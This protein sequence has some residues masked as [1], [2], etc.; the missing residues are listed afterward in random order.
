MQ[1]IRLKTEYLTNPIG[2]DYASPRLFW[3]CIDGSRQTAYELNIKNEDNLIIYE[4]KKVLTN[5]M[6]FDCPIKLEYK[7]RYTWSIRLYDEKDNV[8]KYSSAY[9]ELG[10]KP[11]ERWQ[12]NW[13]TGNYFVNPFKRYKVDYLK[14]E[15][16]S[17]RIKKARLY[18][19]ACGLYYASINNQKVGDGVLTP[20]ISDYRKRVQYQTY[21]VTDLIKEGNNTINVELTD[22]WYRGC[23]GAWGIRNQYGFQTKMLAILELTDI[24]NVVTKI[25]TDDSWSWSNDGEIICAD[26]KDGEIV[27]ARLMPTY[28]KN[29][30]ITNHNVIP[31]CSNNTLISEHECFKPELIITPSGKKVL[32][33]KQNFAG[34]ISFKIKAKQGEK[35]TLLFGELLNNDKEFS[36]DN[37]QL[38]MKNKVTPLQKIEYTCKEGINEYKT[39]FAIFGYQYVLVETNI[40]FNP[41]DFI[42]IALYTDMEE[43]GT[44]ESSNE[45]LNQ[46][47]RNVIWSTKSNS[48]DLPTDCPTRERHGWTGDAQIF[49]NTFLYL[50]D[51]NAFEQKYLNDIYDFQKPNGKLPHIAPIGGSD[52][53]MDGMNGSTGWADAGIIIPYTLYKRYQDERILRKYLKGMEKYIEFMKT[54]C[55]QFY[56]TAKPSHLHGEERRY[57]VNSG[58]SYGEWA[59]PSDVHKMTWVDCAIPHPESSTAYTIYMLDLMSEIEEILGYRDKAKEYKDFSNKCRKSYQALIEKNNEYSLDTNRQANLVRPL[60]LNL[61]NNKQEEFAKQRLIKALDNYDWRIGTGFLSTPLILDVLSKIDKEYA[62]RLLENT[63]CPGWLN[64]AKNSTTIW[65]AWEGKDTSNGGIASLNHYSKGAMCA[66]LFNS[67]CGINVEKD[68]HF[69]IKPLPGGSFTYSKASYMSIYGEVISEWKKTSKGYEYNISIP[70]NTWATIVLPNGKTYNQNLRSKHYES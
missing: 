9:F 68:N 20:G 33:F 30:R 5:K 39:K 27:D 44:F 23:C 57:L 56:I 13:I 51:A 54:R 16:V 48:A 12:A 19:T 28:S 53:Y 2:I 40:D 41:D 6:Y 60:A 21:D 45:L 29:A 32:D 55:G 24:S 70:V 43:V 67:M 36:Q 11:N 22:G 4:S 59:E 46:F 8:G 15:F 63:K 26:N 1:A 65:E 35:I 31:T 49:A 61:L 37:I 66:W 14:K 62:Y 47:V 10:L 64:M 52:F 50:F 58:Q 17:K 42:G 69:V 38:K 18:I 25:I 34:Y 3:N 7:Q